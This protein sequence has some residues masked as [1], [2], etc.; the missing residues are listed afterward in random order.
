MANFN[1]LEMAHAL[2]SHDN[3]SV[4]S[5]MFG[6]KKHLVY[7]PTGSPV[8]VQRYNYNIDAVAPLQRII[9]TDTS[10]LAAAVKA[11]R[12]PQQEVGNVELEVCMSQDKQFVAL[13]L[14]QYSDEC[15]YHPVSAP[16]IYEGAAAQLVAGIL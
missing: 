16:A 13:Q 15:I 10:G 12:S 8:K 1:N 3:L 4:Q 14:M 9:E 2:L 5:A 11:F 6:L 7:V